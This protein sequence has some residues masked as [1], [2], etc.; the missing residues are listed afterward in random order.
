M[1]AV[2]GIVACV[3]WPCGGRQRGVARPAHHVVGGE[4]HLLRD[5]DVDGVFAIFFA[6]IG[7]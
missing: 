7:I 1:A 6:A 4:K 5:R 3:E 2:I